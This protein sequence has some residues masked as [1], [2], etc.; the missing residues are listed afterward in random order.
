[1]R[2][3]PEI[4]MRR[5]VLAF[6][7]LVLAIPMAGSAPAPQPAA[8]PLLWKVS[9]AD[10]TVYLL[11]SFHLLKKSDYPLP[12]DIDR[13]FD[14]AER[15]VFEIAPEELHDPALPMKMAQ[16]AMQPGDAAF[17]KVAS[18]DMAARVGAEL[19]KLGLPAAQFGQFEPWMVSITLVSVVGQQLG[20]SGED[21]LDRHLMQRAKEA[22][23]PTGG[24]ETIE[25]QLDAM[26]S[27]PVAEQLASLAETVSD[28]YDM[29]AR[30]G[31]LHQAWRTADVA[32]LERVAVEEM[33]S[34]TPE[35][36]RRL[37]VERNR[38]WMPRLEG[39]LAGRDDVLVVVGAMHLLGSDGLLAQLESKGLRVERVCT[40]CDAAKA[41]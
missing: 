19:T 26:D 12:A 17:A 29:P 4:P 35:S 40:G 24:L 27:T 37:N 8:R 22:G 31:E 23:K 10:S 34:K 15:L 16:R 28:G 9:D 13:A 36:Y 30:L 32:L 3:D 33:R 20:Y 14:D 21:G 11:G 38:A 41:R 18:P 39:L 25:S 7:S 5:L 2:P 1:M 6:A